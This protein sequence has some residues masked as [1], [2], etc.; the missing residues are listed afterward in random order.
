MLNIKQTIRQTPQ[1]KTL[2]AKVTRRSPRLF[3]LVLWL[4]LT[5]ITACGGLGAEPQIVATFPA[6]ADAP[7]AQLIASVPETAPDIALGAQ[8]FAQH[9]TQCHGVDG[10]GNGPLVQSG[11]VPYPGNFRDPLTARDQTPQQWFTTIT[12]GRIENLMPPWVNELTEAERWALAMYTYTLPYTQEQIALGADVW[13]GE[14][15]R[16]HG[17]F[18]LGDGP[19]AAQNS[20]PSVSLA[21]QSE[22]V[23]LR[24][25]TLQV[26]TA[27]GIGEAMPAYQDIL[28]ADQL[29]AVVAYTRTLSLHNINNIGVIAQAPP[30]ETTAE[31]S[32][33][34]GGTASA[35]S[36][37]LI[38][39]SFTI[40]G[41][42]TNGTAGT[43]PVSAGLP[44]TLL[45][46]EL[47]PTTQAILGSEQRQTTT[48]AN[49][50]YSFVDIPYAR[51]YAYAV[52]AS[53]RERNF[54]GQPVSGVEIGTDT[55]TIPITIYELTDNTGVISITGIEMRITGIAPGR[56]QIVQQ[57]I[58]NNSSDRVF[59]SDFGGALDNPA[60]VAM[61]LPPGAVGLTL[62][63]E[64]RFIYIEEEG[65]LVDTFP[66][67]PGEHI[68]QFAY[69]LPYND[70]GAIIEFPIF[71]PFTGALNLYLAPSTLRPSGTG[72]TSRV[73]EQVEGDI[74][75]TGYTQPYN[76]QPSTPVRFE[77][78]GSAGS[79]VQEFVENTSGTISGETLLPLL[80]IG[81]GGALLLTGLL[82]YRRKGIKK[83]APKP[84]PKVSKD[85]IINALI[86]QIAELDEQHDAGQLNHDV[87]HRR[88]AQLKERLAQL[89]DQTDDS[90]D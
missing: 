78:S 85:R 31:A 64:S 8:L 59:Q 48:D 3:P 74:A 90:A 62:A 17:E 68:V 32:A 44:V 5:L 76:T 7:T 73:I 69:G 1:N 41:T 23:T 84:A 30:A 18:G 63:N 51:E 40:R 60:S 20:R 37:P 83:T 34:N 35:P 55:L 42:V 2:S 28:S 70:L 46:V 50:N 4:L 57:I 22:M 49:G 82:L 87:Y 38:G 9:C 89:M 6:A 67:L 12:A 53:Y 71:Y 72:M 43:S 26:I 11:E 10:S 45:I 36:T 75:Y 77:L 61:A 52:S 13:I 65:F 21:A 39:S 14:C 24:D 80:M 66:I 25:T 58:F 19:D 33:Q 16:C 86:R 81:G 47:D 54:P 15:V 79:G 27:E 29:N 88:R 56:L